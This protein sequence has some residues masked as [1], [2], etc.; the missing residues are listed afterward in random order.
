VTPRSGAGFAHMD[1]GWTF[2][3]PDYGPGGWREPSDPW[4]V[5]ARHPEVLRVHLLVLQ[6]RAIAPVSVLGRDPIDRRAERQW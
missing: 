1:A 4:Q 2:L 5:P 3:H 6:F